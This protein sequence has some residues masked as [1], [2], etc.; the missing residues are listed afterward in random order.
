MGL[1]FGKISGKFYVASN[2]RQPQKHRTS[3]AR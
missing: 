2:P 3:Y 1:G